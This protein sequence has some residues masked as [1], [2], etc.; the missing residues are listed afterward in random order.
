MHDDAHNNDS[1]AY[2]ELSDFRASQQHNHFH[3][4]ILQQRTRRLWPVANVESDYECGPGGVGDRTYSQAMTPEQT[5][6]TLWEIQMAGGYTAYYYTYT[7]WDV[8]RPLDV[9]PGYGYLKHFGEFWRTTAY[10]KLEPSD[11]LVN[12]GWCLSDPGQEYVVY[13]NEPHPF[14]L[15]LAGI[16]APLTGEWFNPLTGSH[17]AVGTFGNGPATFTPPAEWGNCAARASSR[18][19]ITRRMQR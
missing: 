10:W 3:E 9:P 16:E 5:L 1:G 14:M 12:H 11:K 17:S 15:E 4:T 6:R 19:E 13:Q 2:D 8:I 7:A 18:G